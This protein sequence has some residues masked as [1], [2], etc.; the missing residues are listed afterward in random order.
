M[1]VDSSPD[2][3]RERLIEAA[4]EIF[5]EVGFKSA[6]VREICQRGK[7]NVAA[8]NYHFGDKQSLYYE[9]VRAAHCSGPGLTNVVWPPEM[10]PQ[11]KLRVFIKKWLEHYL[12]SSRPSWHMRLMLREMSDPTEA[13]EKLVQDYI[14]PMANVLR[15]IVRELMPPEHLERNGM[16]VGF[17]IIG[18]CLF[19]KI[20][21]P[22]VELLMGLDEFNKL[23][24]DVL[25]EHI[26][27][28][29]L[30][31][32]GKGPPLTGVPPGKEHET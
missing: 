3:T 6:T 22:I 19:Y 21:R 30:A 2:Q 27:T 15:E 17:S 25:A 5:A 7:A 16:L 28:F 24:I 9:A 8:I 20:N 13:C 26:S 14:R 1:V 4:G 18:Q 12:D 11:E 10:A 23:T 32:L 29:S 31:A